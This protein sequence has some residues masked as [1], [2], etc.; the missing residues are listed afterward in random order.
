MKKL[1]ILGSDFGTIDIAVKAKKLGYYVITADLMET[2]P[3]KEASD[4]KWLIS[5]VDTEELIRLCRV[6]GINGVIAGASDFN[7]EKS[8]IIAQALGLPTPYDNPLAEKAGNNKRFFKDKCIENGVP[9]ARDY[10]LSSETDVDKADISF[11]VVVKP[12]DAS[13]NRGM[14]YC[15]NRDELKNA[16]KKAFEISHSSTII[17]EKELS[18][19]EY[20]AHYVVKEGEPYLLYFASEKHEPGQRN[21]MYS[22]VSTTSAHLQQYLVEVNEGIKKV[23]RQVGC[24]NGIAWVECIRDK[25]GRFYCFEMGYRLGATMLYTQYGKVCGF[26][27][28]EYLIKYAMDE[29][30]G[31]CMELNR[32]YKEKSSSYHLFMAKSGTISRIEGIE[33]IS[34]MGNVIIDMPKREGTEVQPGRHLGVLRIYS[35]DI[36]DLVNTLSMINEH[37]RIL[38][39]HGNDMLIHFTDYATLI[40][41]E[42]TGK[43]QYGC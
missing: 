14:S 38:D 3:T 23:F 1:L 21:N 9:V 2:S 22:L 30:T 13:G 33:R 43:E 41:E 6:H 10:Y 28:I 29:P 39:E 4:E 11:P 15:N 35:V 18:G 32:Y 40:R 34:C 5:T 16:I 8:K 42:K 12:V 19:P 7:N 24:T 37:L 26:D 17:V 27:A 36:N 20:A 31:D 25:D